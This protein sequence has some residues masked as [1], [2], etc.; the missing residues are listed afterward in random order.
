MS[1]T[2]DDLEQ[3]N[4][5]FS[6]LE[7]APKHGRLSLRSP[8]VYIGK[9][10]SLVFREENIETYKGVFK[11]YSHVFLSY[12]RKNNAIVME[13]TNNGSGDSTYKLSLSSYGF[14]TTCVS[15]FKYFDI[16]TVKYGGRY[17]VKLEKMSPDKSVWVIYLKTKEER[18]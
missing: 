17:V 8:M 14:V 5:K 4:D 2:F 12:S 9:A 16:D 13:F 18:Q 10:K 11:K 7:M 1:N 15:F 6:D 3:V